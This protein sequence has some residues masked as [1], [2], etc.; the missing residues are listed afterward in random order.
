MRTVSCSTSRGVTS[1]PTVTSDDTGQEY[2]RHRTGAEL[3]GVGE[4]FVFLVV[5]QPRLPGVLQEVGE[6]LTGEDGL[7][8]VPGLDVEETQDHFEQLS[9]AAVTGR[10]SRAK[11]TRAGL[12]HIAV[13]SG[14][15]I[16]RFFGTISPMTRWQ[17]T[18]T[19]SAMT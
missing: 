8:L 16:A 2:V 12:S 5:Q 15:A 13:R 19:A 18:T 14:A 9:S 4:A 10:H 3:Q 6:L 7:D 11:A 1:G 17:E